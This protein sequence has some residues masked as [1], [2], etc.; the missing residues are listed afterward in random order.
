MH[1]EHGV[2][3]LLRI[4]EVVDHYASTVSFGAV[5][6]T[7]MGLVSVRVGEEVGYRASTCG[8]DRF[9]KILEHVGT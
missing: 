1:A 2:L 3:K 8:A 5:D 7:A 9:D 4:F 6:R